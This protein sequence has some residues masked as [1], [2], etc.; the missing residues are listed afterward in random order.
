[1]IYTWKRHYHSRARFARNSIH[2]GS[3]RQVHPLTAS[4][5]SQISFSVY[6][7][8]FLMWL[9]SEFKSKGKEQQI[10]VL[11]LH[12]SI[13]I[14]RARK[15][16]LSRQGHVIKLNTFVV[17]SFLQELWHLFSYPYLSLIQQ[18]FPAWFP[19]PPKIWVLGIFCQ[20]CL[21]QCPK[22]PTS[23]SSRRSPYLQI[24]TQ[25]NSELN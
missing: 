2:Q 8:C 5:S 12:S 21:W 17:L 16:C 25:W 6:N 3:T 20:I 19:F 13:V 7:K 11:S 23:F 22:C 18:E 15:Y 10:Y 1:M 14:N 4:G 9:S 24:S